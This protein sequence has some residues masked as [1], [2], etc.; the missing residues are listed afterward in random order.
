MAAPPPGTLKSISPSWHLHLSGLDWLFDLG[1]TSSFRNGGETPGSTPQNCRMKWSNR[2]SVDSEGGGRGRGVAAALA[3]E[4]RNKKC[5]FLLASV[6]EWPR[7]MDFD[8]GSRPY[9][10]VGGEHPE[11]SLPSVTPPN[12]A[13]W[14]RQIDLQSILAPA[15]WAR[16]AGA[17]GEG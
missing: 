6:S 2:L 4:K 17:K 8:F 15:N 3:V 1:S 16:V 13:E 11:R 7:S 14:R 10:W 9:F 5:A 12:L